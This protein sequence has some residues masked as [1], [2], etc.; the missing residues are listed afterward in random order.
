M[1]RDN[2]NNVQQQLSKLLVELIFYALIIV[3]L[4]FVHVSENK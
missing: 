2:I 3:N 4:Q 1:Y